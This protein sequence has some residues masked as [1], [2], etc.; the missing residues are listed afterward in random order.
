[1]KIN[2]D[3]VFY[4]VSASHCQLT[5]VHK[6][7]SCFFI[8]ARF[9]KALHRIGGRQEGSHVYEPYSRLQTIIILYQEHSSGSPEAGQEVKIKKPLTIF[10]QPCNE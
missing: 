1:M 4:Y 2:F 3:A 6:S 8:T 7:G 10:V 5:F 9:Q